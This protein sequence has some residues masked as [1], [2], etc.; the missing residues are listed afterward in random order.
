MHI[1]YKNSVSSLLGGFRPDKIFFGIQ[2][3][4]I[5]GLDS[6]QTECAVQHALSRLRIFGHQFTLPLLNLVSKS[7]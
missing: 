4:I 7:L 2:L 6:E 1:K 3:K 5:N